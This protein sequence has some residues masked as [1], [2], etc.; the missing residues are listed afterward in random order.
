MSLL[1]SIIALVVIMNLSKR[2]KNLEQSIGKLGGVTPVMPESMPITQ[3]SPLTTPFPAPAVSEAVAPQA[4][5]LPPR[6]Q[7]PSV[8]ETFFQW[9]SVDWPMKLGAVLLF[10]AFGWIVPVFFWD[11][12]GPIGQVTLGF[13][14]GIAIL[15]FGAKRISRYANQG[16]VLLGLGAGI[17]FI[18]V[19]A[20]RTQYDFFSPFTA[21]LFMFLVAVFVAYVSVVRKNLP[22]AF[23]GLFLGGV[24]PLLVDPSEPSVFGLFSYLFVLIVGT[25]WV[26][27]L[28]GWRELSAASIALYALYAAPLMMSS[29]TL[30]PDQGTKMGIAIL[31]ALAFFVASILSVI[32]D[33]KSESS[34]LVVSL[35]NGLLLL[36]WIHTIIAPEWQ[37]FMA[38]LTA[39]IATIGAF[40]VYSFTGLREPVYIHSVVAGV[41]VGMATAYELSGSILAIAYILEVTALVLGARF[42]LNDEGAVRKA[43][44]VSILP[45][46]LSLV[47]IG[48]YAREEEV[49]TKNFF[50][51]LLMALMFFI[52]AFILRQRQAVSDGNVSSSTACAVLGASY[53]LILVW[54]STHIALEDDQATMLS[55]F[56]Y[57][58]VG[59][60]LYVKGK[61]SG[62]KNE[63][64][65]GAVLLLGVT[66]HLLLVDVWDMDVMGRIIIFSIIG[67]L[68]MSTAFIGKKKEVQ[69]V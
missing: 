3:P 27:R 47:S 11:A 64:T 33:R 54:L 6:P 50:V 10:F 62:E 43:M 60:A 35:V 1:L 39:L 29:S 25:L 21:L 7:T 65:L 57:T 24:A 42:I 36:G 22:V 2:V 13:L 34:D 67:V 37:S 31:F 38:V 26:V 40:S 28:T 15:F 56:L 63:K 17:I 9:F 46:I 52:F 16:S 32:H 55:L 18:T 48:H 8:L 61:I 53:G 49:F 5:P 59:M 58:I 45:V 12:I 4:P 66:A 69:G 68:F 14:F 20:A 30:D 19:F 23:L 44:L 41:F 51:L